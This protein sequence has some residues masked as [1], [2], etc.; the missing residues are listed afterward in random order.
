M[1]D[2]LGKEKINNKITECPHCKSN[3]GYYIKQQFSGKGKYYLSFDGKEI[4]NS[5]FHDEIKYSG[6]KIAYCISCGKKI[7]N[8]DDLK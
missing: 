4:D 1:A 7:C 3:D 2:L 6:G 5:S 8:I